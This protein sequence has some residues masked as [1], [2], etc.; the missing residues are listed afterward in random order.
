MNNISIIIGT[1]LGASEYIAD[2]LTEQLEPNYQVTNYLTPKLSDFDTTQ[3]Q[4]WI[5]CTST[6]GAGDFPDNILTFV[7]NLEKQQ[8]D[9]SNIR[10]AVCALGDSNYDT[11]CFAGKKMDQLLGSLGAQRLIDPKLIDISLG[12]LPEDIAEIWLKNWID[13]LK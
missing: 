4:T 3:Q 6:H 1:M 12:D 9:L 8:P 7:E 10:F 5:V 2:R 13:L 11:F